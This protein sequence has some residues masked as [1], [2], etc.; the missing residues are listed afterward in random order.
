M[1]QPQIFTRQFLFSAVYLAWWITL[2]SFILSGGYQSFIRPSFV[3]FLWG[4]LAILLVFIVS[5]F[6]EMERHNLRF[7]DMVRGG[8]IL[9]PLISL[10][11]AYGKPLGTYAYMKKTVMAPSPPL[12]IPLE[13]T[14]ENF[15]GG[16]TLEKTELR[17]NNEPAPIH[18]TIL[19][20]LKQPEKYLGKIIVTDGMALRQETFRKDAPSI[21]GEFTPDSFMLFRFRIVCCVADSQPL[22]LIV[23]YAGGEKVMD[24]DWYR[25]TGRF[26]QNKEQIGIIKRAVV[27]NL[28]TPPDPPYL[29][30]NMN[31]QPSTDK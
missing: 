2:L 15:A 25:V 6:G 8:I 23:K 9:L 11:I 19:E 7:A 5:G 3:I 4:A 16:K 12:K 29:F 1:K 17:R 20:L 31:L 21:P 30:E 26:Y 28:E 18:V 27:S 22:G 14:S 13:A 24:N 10:W